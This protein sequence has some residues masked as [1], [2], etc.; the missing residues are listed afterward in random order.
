MNDYH[1]LGS[2]LECKKETPEEKTVRRRQK[3]SGYKVELCSSEESL[4]RKKSM[5]KGS[6]I[7]VLKRGK[8][9]VKKGSSK[10]EAPFMEKLWGNIVEGRPFPEWEE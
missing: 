9:W 10:R 8:S 2:Q 5:K 1:S 6:A 3:P 7:K 4:E